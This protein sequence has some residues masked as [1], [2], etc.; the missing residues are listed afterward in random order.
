MNL[1]S[2]NGVVKNKERYLTKDIFASPLIYCND[3][4]E[5]LEFFRN[6]VLW[7][8]TKKIKTAIKQASKRLNVHK[9]TNK[10]SHLYKNV[11]YCHKEVYSLSYFGNIKVLNYR[12]FQNYIVSITVKSLYNLEVPP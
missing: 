11:H 4:S 1:R 5:V 9:L 2:T 7:T 10:R 3:F 6:T 12:C 8:I